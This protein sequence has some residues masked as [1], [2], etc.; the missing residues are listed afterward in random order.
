[1]DAQPEVIVLACCGHRA[2]RTL[3]DLPILGQYPGWAGLPAVKNGRVYAVDANAYFSRP[4]PRIVDSL[5]ILAEIL[6][7]E[8]FRDRFPDRGVRRVESAEDF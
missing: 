8:L 7:P 1:V 5:E 6:H 4:G 3:E 2:E